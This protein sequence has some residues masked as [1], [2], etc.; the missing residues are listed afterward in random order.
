M[1]RGLAPVAA[2]PPSLDFQQICDAIDKRLFV[3]KV[4]P[5]TTED[6]LREI[7]SEFGALTECRV[8]PDR[9]GGNSNGIGFVGFQSWAA[10][11]R[12]L[13]ETDGKRQFR[14]QV[15]T[16]HA[17]IASFAENMSKV[18]RGGGA[19]YAKGLTVNRVFVGQVPEDATDQELGGRFA[20]CGLVE[21]VSLLQP[22]NRLRCAFV[23][24]NN[25]GEAMDAVELMN[26]QPLRAGSE[27]GMMVQLAMPKD[28]P[29]SV[30]PAGT[31]TFGGGR[32]DAAPGGPPPKRLRDGPASVDLHT[33]LTAYSTAALQDSPR[34]TLDLLHEQIIRAR[35]INPRGNYSSA[36]AARPAVAQGDRARLFVGGLPNDMVDDDLG[37]LAAQVEFSLPRSHCELLECRVLTGK[38]CGYLK[39][40]TVE[41]AQEALAALNNRQVAGWASPLRVQWASPHAG[42]H[43]DRLSSGGGGSHGHGNGYSRISQASAMALVG[44]PHGALDPLCFASRHEVEAQGLDPT[45]LFIGQLFRNLPDADQTLHP[46][47]EQYGQMRE[48]RWVADKGILYATY[49][50]FEEAQAAMQGLSGRPIEGISKS[51]NVKYSQRR[52]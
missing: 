45:R 19:A 16:S 3:G 8:V 11:F 26:G 38:G 34:G 5:H 2:G 1:K 21:S 42:S 39:Y 37:A 30:Q 12:A 22:K 9:N 25:W 36:P 49:N 48:F 23:T 29:R 50:T 52:P 17:M 31:P 44:E 10:A 20:S 13:Q 6:E 40:T 18:G 27:P 35:E 33:L 24:Y 46:L 15:G 51:L 43:G 4:P 28:G 7:F 41:A 32:H 47:F 14:S